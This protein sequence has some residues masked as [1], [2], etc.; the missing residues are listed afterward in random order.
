MNTSS[1]LKITNTRSRRSILAGLAALPALGS[2]A[3]VAAISGDADA[4]L[5]EAIR[6]Y[7]AAQAAMIA[8][9]SSSRSSGDWDA[10]SNIVSEC[11]EAFAELLTHNPQT[12]AGCVAMLRAIQL[13][14]DKNE[15]SIFESWYEPIKDPASTLLGRIAARLAT[16][17]SQGSAVQS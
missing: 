5:M 15:T 17:L 16:H 7:E 2:A 4:K 10:F 14:C 1:E 6:N 12:P 13:F 3:A 9:E 8:A 11:T